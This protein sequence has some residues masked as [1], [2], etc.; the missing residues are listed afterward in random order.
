[1]TR[2]RIAIITEEKKLFTSVEFNGDMYPDGC[3]EDAMAILSDIENIEE[4]EKRVCEFNNNNYGYDDNP[5]V[6]SVDDV[7]LSE[8]LNMAENYYNYWFVD[9]IY[10]KNISEYDIEWTDKTGKKRVLFSGEIAVI[11]SGRY[12]GLDGDNF[13]AYLNFMQQ[14]SDLDKQDLFALV[15][16]DMIDKV[17]GI[18]EDTYDVGASCVTELCELPDWIN[19]SRYINYANIGEDEVENT[20]A[21]FKLPSGKFAHLS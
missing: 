7:E 19:N 21:W 16:S 10:I 1:M 9:Y 5:L 18:Y 4:F 17:C 13:N 14:Y 12:T 2:G 15:Q 6:F 8:T 11:S 20:D 3:G